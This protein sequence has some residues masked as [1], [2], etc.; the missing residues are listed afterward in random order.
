MKTMIDATIL[1]AG[2]KYLFPKN[3]GIVALSRCWDI[4]LVLLPKITQARSEPK[5]A[6]PI[7]IQVDA[8]PNFQPN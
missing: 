4:S 7:P 5:I 8:I 3:S 6:F 2:L 1:S